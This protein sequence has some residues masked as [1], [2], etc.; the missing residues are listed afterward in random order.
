[1]VKRA[2]PGL[3][4]NG[5]GLMCMDDGMSLRDWFAGQAMAGM[6]ADSCIVDKAENIAVIAY[7]VAD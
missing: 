3:D 6:M 5:R 7:H 4:D 2:F 1:M